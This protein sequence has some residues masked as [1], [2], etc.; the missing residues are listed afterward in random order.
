MSS[1]HIMDLASWDRACPVLLPLGS[2]TM[3][4]VFIASIG[5]F[6][7]FVGFVIALF[8]Y[9]HTLWMGNAEADT[10]PADLLLTKPIAAV[11]TRSSYADEAYNKSSSYASAKSSY[12]ANSDP[13]SAPSWRP[14]SNAGSYTRYAHGSAEF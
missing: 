11:P 6:I 13:K 1:S 5:I 7:P 8:M 4:S 2:P 14:A 10:A 12:T 9:L 3:S